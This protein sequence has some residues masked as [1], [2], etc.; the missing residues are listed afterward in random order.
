MV[1]SILKCVISVFVAIKF[2]NTKAEFNLLICELLRLLPWT[3]LEHTQ[4]IFNLS[5]K[6]SLTI[7]KVGIAETLL[8]DCDLFWS[9]FFL[10]LS[11]MALL[12]HMLWT[13]VQFPSW[14][15][16]SFI[17]G[18]SHWLRLSTFKSW[19]VLKVFYQLVHQHCGTN[20]LAESGG[21]MHGDRRPTEEGG[22]AVTVVLVCRV[23][24]HGAADESTT[25]GLIIYLLII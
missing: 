16:P 13:Q 3:L 10:V 1:T 24:Q 4:C 25:S 17:V 12:G 22:T 18:V 8:F 14:T 7:L 5:L 19:Q 23:V 11:I 15:P 2:K 21:W 9:S 6:A 20:A